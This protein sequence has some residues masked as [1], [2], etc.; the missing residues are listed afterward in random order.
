MPARMLSV[1]LDRLGDRMH[2]PGDLLSPN[3]PRQLLAGREDIAE[4]DHLIGAISPQREILRMVG[5]VGAGPQPKRRLHPGG[6][7][8]ARA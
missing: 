4:E 1:G 8:A 2:E 5:V 7:A 3:T 6:E